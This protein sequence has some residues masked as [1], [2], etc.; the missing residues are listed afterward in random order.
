MQNTTERLTF[1]P[2]AFDS[3]MLRIIAGHVQAKRQTPFVS[4]SDTMRAALE[5][6]A[7]AIMNRPTGPERA[8]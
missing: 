1:R 5:I 2:T 7:E 3:R 4:P 6:A 8:E